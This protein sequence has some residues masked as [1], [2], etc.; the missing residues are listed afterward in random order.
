MGKPA[1]SDLISVSEAAK[2]LG[3]GER[4]VRNLCEDAILPAVKVGRGWI[5]KRSDLAKV[6]KDRKPGPKPTD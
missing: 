3:L 2:A 1:P 4:Q 5:I 6:P